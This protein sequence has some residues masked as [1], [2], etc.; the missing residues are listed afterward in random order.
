[1]DDTAIGDLMSIAGR[2]DRTKFRNQ[3]LR[4]LLQAE[5]LQMGRA[6]LAARDNA[7]A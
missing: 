7:A 5:L 6:W 3:I 4:P 1:M 2:A